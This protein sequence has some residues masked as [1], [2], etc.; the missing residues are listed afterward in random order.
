MD[1]GVVINCVRIIY[2]NAAAFDGSSLAAFVAVGWISGQCPRA[3]G[4]MN[5]GERPQ[6]RNVV[7]GAFAMFTVFTTAC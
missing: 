4:G 2:G 6:S 1:H 5:D 3:V 7:R